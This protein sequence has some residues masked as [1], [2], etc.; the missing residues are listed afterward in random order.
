MKMFTNMGRG[1]LTTGIATVGLI[2]TAISCIK[3][4]KAVKK[5]EKESEET[6]KTIEEVHEA[7]MSDKL[8]EECTYTEDDYM[9]DKFIVQVKKVVLE[10]L[11]IGS[12]ILSCLIFSVML[13]LGS[14][15]FITNSKEV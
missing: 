14:R 3:T 15:Q 1:L 7:A 8:G 6:L 11:Y 13:I 4:I 12:A 9:D 10:T 2:I 5:I